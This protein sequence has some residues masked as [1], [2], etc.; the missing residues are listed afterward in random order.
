MCMCVF[1]GE[2]A[3][4]WRWLHG[5]DQVACEAGE[6]RRPRPAVGWPYRR[7]TLLPGLPLLLACRLVQGKEK[8]ATIEV[9][10][11]QVKLGIPQ[12]SG[13]PCC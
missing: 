2:G 1:W 11:E 5:D 13:D 4:K 8:G 12:A 7:F 10:G 9:D 3:W 6:G